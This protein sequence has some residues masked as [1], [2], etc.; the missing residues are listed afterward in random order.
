VSII[1]EAYED[2]EGIDLNKIDQKQ[3]YLKPKV[4]GEL[5]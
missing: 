5:I 2:I 4:I 1:F 3:D